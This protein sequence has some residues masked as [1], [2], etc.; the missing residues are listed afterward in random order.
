MANN[1]AVWSGPRNLST[2]LMYSFS[3]RDDCFAIDEPFYAHYLKQTGKNHPLRDQVLQH[4]SHNLD[5]IIDSLVNPTNN[6]RPIFYQKHMTHHMLPEIPLNWVKQLKNVFL[7]RHPQRV[8]AS[9]LNR[10]DSV[11]F[12]DI[13]FER[14]WHLYRQF[15]AMGIESIVID[16]DTIL[17]NS[18]MVLTALCQHLKI[19]FSKQMLQWQAGARP[20]D[21]IWAPHW[22]QS[23]WKSTGFT[24]HNPN[25]P[26]VATE[27]F[28]V[29]EQALPIYQK[30]LQKHLTID[31]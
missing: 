13:G 12:A 9:Y 26:K 15:C 20:C 31:V 16:A 5:S 10:V 21:G 23:V 7:I 19:P 29:V 17:Q 14:Q 6:T 24:Q 4:H 25:L 28:P 18:Q 30:L 8:V 22:Y 3:N 27:F 2:A 1:I 11:S